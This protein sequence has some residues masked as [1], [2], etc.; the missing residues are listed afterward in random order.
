[1]ILLLLLHPETICKIGCHF[2]R[3]KG[4]RPCGPLIHQCAV[5]HLAI[6]R[7]IT[8]GTVIP[9]SAVMLTVM[10]FQGHVKH[11]F[12]PLICCYWYH[13]CTFPIPTKW[14]ANKSSSLL[15]A[16]HPASESLITRGHGVLLLVTIR[17]AEFWFS[18]YYTLYHTGWANRDWQVIWVP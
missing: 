18:Q 5:T 4:C 8:A 1:M 15:N 13:E 16:K 6:A 12:R 9:T 2:Q 7:G 14:W 17:S 11:G 3:L 10:F